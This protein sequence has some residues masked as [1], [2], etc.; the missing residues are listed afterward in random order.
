M[1]TLIHSS[2]RTVVTVFVDLILEVAFG[3][4]LRSL[5]ALAEEP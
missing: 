2:A 1:R 3:M 5:A 4:F